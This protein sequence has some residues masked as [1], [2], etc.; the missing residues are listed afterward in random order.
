MSVAADRFEPEKGQAP[1]R[2]HVR[3]VGHDRVSHG[4]FL[5]TMEGEDEEH[6]WHRFLHA[7]Q[8]VLPESGA[9][10]HVTG[11]RLYRWPL[12]NLPEQVPVFAAVNRDDPRPRR[13]GLVCS[14]LTRKSST[15]MV[16]GFPVEEPEEVLLRAA[17]DLGV[18]DLVPMIDHALRCGDLTEGPMTMILDSGRPGVGVLRAA[19]ELSCAKRES[20]MESLFGVFH[21]AMEIP[22]EPQVDLY[23][24]Q[25][26]FIGRADFLVIGTNRI[27]EYDGA[28]HREKLQHRKDLRRE[29]GQTSSAYVRKGFTLDDLLNHPAVVMHEMDRDLGRPHRNRR[30]RRWRILVRES[31]YDEVGRARLL[32][33]WRRAMGVVQW[34]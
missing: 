5:P 6:L 32:N 29:R 23:D 31:L 30:L 25:G 19:W 13:E 33:R 24:D 18:L 3:S 17:R 16:D 20:A 21:A 22:V 12:P 4:L 2:G 26:T 15:R 11:A 14:R 1:I 27:H 28:D 34:S 7:W 8:Q 10:T 9:F